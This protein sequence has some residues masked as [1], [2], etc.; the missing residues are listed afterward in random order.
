[1]ALLLGTLIFTPLQMGLQPCYSD[2]S[3]GSTRAFERPSRKQI[4]SSI[5]AALPLSI[6]TVAF[7]DVNLVPMDRERVVPH[8][9]VLVA[10]ANDAPSNDPQTK[11]GQGNCLRVDR[12]G[13]WMFPAWLLR[14]ATRERNPANYRNDIMGFRVAR[15]LP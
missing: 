9:T 2:T 4:L 5:Q 15:T 14:P 6:G 1:L 13:W 8:Q 3:P 7:V 11:D 10:R 12:G